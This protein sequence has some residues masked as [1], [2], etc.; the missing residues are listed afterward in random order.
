MK[1]K[2]LTIAVTGMNATDNPG[3]GVGVIRA[4][5]AG[6]SKDRLVGLAYDALDPGIYARDIVREV[7][8]IP[9][10]SQGIEAF[11]S[12]IEY[13]HR[14]V[15]LD[16]IVPTLDAELGSFIELEPKLRSMG[17]G[18][19]LPTREQLEQRSKVRLAELGERA[20]IR[21]PT[22]C[23]VSD[24]EELSRAHDKVPYPLFV[25]GVYYGATLVHTLSEAISAF[26][27]VVSQWGVP[28]ILQTYVP[29]EEFNVVAVGDGKGGMLGAVP[30]KKMV[31]TDKGKGWAGITVKD[32]E[33]LEV[34]RSFMRAT[35]W[36]GPCEVEVLRD[37]DG[38][39]QLIEINP[40]FPAWVFLSAAAGVNLPRMVVDLAAGRKVE[41]VGDYEVGAMFVR[42]ALDQVASIG[43]FQ[44]MVTLGEVTR[45]GGAS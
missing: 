7:F 18:M 15:G 39:Y 13:V 16:V 42:I 10:P 28:V 25:K 29:G 19:V 12:R 37:K 33:L 20:G 30:M 1:N 26:Y 27:K 17:I 43:D 5:A 24:V 38:H 41:P 8:L 44:R 35:K 4:L 36:R 40:R 6:N 31:I 45:S 9:Y 11:L 22:C 23:V 21:V 2:P 14:K 3:P 34:A 32:P